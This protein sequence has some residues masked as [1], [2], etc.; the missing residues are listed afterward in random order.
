MKQQLRFFHPNSPNH[1]YHLHKSLYGLKQSLKE[2]FTKLTAYLNSIIFHNSKIDTFLYF[3]HNNNI[4]YFLLL[5]VD[6]IL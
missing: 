5:C 4:P 2:W 6:D 1:V 3:S